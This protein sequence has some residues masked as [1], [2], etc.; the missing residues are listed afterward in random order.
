[1]K[2]TKDQDMAYTGDN[3]E[4]NEYLLRES[5]EDLRA[6]MSTTGMGLVGI[7]NGSADIFNKRTAFMLN[8]NKTPKGSQMQMNLTNNREIA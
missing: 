8:K 6:S 5:D 1:M 2:T 4:L 7:S 3:E